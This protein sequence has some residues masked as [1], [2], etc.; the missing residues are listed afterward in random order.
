[1]GEDGMKHVIVSAFICAV[2]N[3]IT[4][5]W[6]AAFITFVIGMFKEA[7]DYY[8]GRGCSEFKDITC[9][10]IGILITTIATI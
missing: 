8:S 7:Y 3:L 4:P 2:F 1:M 10:T 9:N 5:V 6:G